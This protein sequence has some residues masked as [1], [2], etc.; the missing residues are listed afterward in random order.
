MAALARHIQT[1]PDLSHLSA[2]VDCALTRWCRPRALR[3]DVAAALARIT[4][5]LRR[6]EDERAFVMA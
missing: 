3:A 4:A 6:E 5:R 1:T 2:F